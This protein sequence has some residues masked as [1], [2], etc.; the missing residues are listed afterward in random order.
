M[1][2]SNDVINKLNL[3]INENKIKVIVNRTIY[4]TIIEIIWLYYDS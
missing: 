2:L 1:V 4:T 3:E